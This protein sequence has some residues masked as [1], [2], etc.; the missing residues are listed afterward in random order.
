[1]T[2]DSTLAILESA[3][4]SP[5]PGLAAQET[6]APV[7]RREWPRNFN[8]ADIRHAAGLLLLFPLNDQAHVVLTV[9]ADSLVR[10]GGQIS[11][12]GGVVEPGETV[13]QA[14]LREA[15]EEVSL[16]SAR[17]TV[18]GALTPVDIPV[19]GFRLHPVVAAAD[20]RPALHPSDGEVSRILEIPVAAFLDPASF[21]RRTMMREGRALLV[22]AFLVEGVEIWGAT[23]MAL[24]EFLWLL[25][26]RG[27]A[28]RSW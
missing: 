8:L 11:M 21:G 18:L 23:A 10:H 14:A 26:W 5:L 22:P 16:D 27:P 17:V 6:L 7:P 2:Y 3:F 25:G 9:R 4:R 12:P 1:V 28:Q 15:H 19:S 24:T 13:A 20:H